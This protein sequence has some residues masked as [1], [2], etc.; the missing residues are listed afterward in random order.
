MKAKNF[1]LGLLFPSLLQAQAQQ[2][3]TS[4]ALSPDGRVVAIS[5]SGEPMQKNKPQTQ[6]VDVVQRRELHSIP[7]TA[8]SM[9]FNGNDGQYLDFGGLRWEW[10][11]DSI[12]RPLSAIEDAYLYHPR[13]PQF[14]YLPKLDAFCGIE[15][16]GLLLYTRSGYE[17]LA[18]SYYNQ[19]LLKNR[20]EGDDY[21][22][23]YLSDY[24]TRENSYSTRAPWHNTPSLGCDHAATFRACAANADESV[25][26]FLFYKDKRRQEPAL[27]LLH[28]REQRTQLFSLD[29]LENELLELLSFS[30]DGRYALVAAGKY[31][32]R[33]ELNK[34]EQLRSDSVSGGFFTH[35]HYSPDGSWIIGATPNKIY[36]WDKEGKLQTSA[37]YPNINGIWFHPDGKHYLIEQLEEGTRRLEYYRLPNHQLVERFDGLHLPYHHASN[38]F[39]PKTG[40]L[41]PDGK[42]FLALTTDRKDWKLI[43][44]LDY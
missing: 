18:V 3:I 2:E 5:Y 17:V 25:I 35:L 19:E 31:W 27:G 32:T 29:N 16:T 36:C 9:Q 8:Y 1:L 41:T 15:S 22:P 44:L 39:L 13:S 10:R 11:F 4:I 42:R 12:L 30:P 6:I 40:L 20:A 26:G 24:S 7:R 28:L 34:G 37:S 14:D 23:Y 21:S 43:D 33:I 38:Y